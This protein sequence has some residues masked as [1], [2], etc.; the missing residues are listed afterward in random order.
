MTIQ[1]IC[2]RVFGM[3]VA[4]CVALS[5]HAA[6]AKPDWARLTEKEIVTDR[7]I[8]VYRDEAVTGRGQKIG[9]TRKW[10]ATAS[11]RAVEPLHRQLGARVKGRFKII[12]AEVI[13]LPEGAD[14]AAVVAAYEAN[15]SV[16][17]VYP[18]YRYQASAHTPNDA[19]WE[20]LWG[21]RRIRADQAW[22]FFPVTNV[23]PVVVA[24]IDS[25]V[26]MN[27]PDLQGM[28]WTNPGEIPGNG[29]DDDGNGYIDDV[30]GW[31]FTTMSLQTPAGDND[32]SD[33]NG[34][35]TH[36]AG[37]IAAT[38]DNGIGVAGVCPAVRILPVRGLNAEG[39][40]STE[41]LGQ[42]IE[43]VA[44]LGTLYPEVK[45]SNNSWGSFGHDMFIMM[46]IE[47]TRMA[48]QLFVAAA[49]NESVNIDFYDSQPGGLPN[50]NIVCVASINESNRLS[51]FSN[52]G[53]ENVDIAA[54][55]GTTAA[56]ATSGRQIM[57][58][59]FN[60]TGSDGEYNG[61]SG[62]SMASPHV[63][64][65]AAYLWAI[66][67]NLTYQQVAA[68]L[69]TGAAV[70][71][72]LAGRVAGAR[73]LDLM[74]AIESLYFKPF[75]K[76]R[77]Y[78]FPPDFPI[79]DGGIATSELTSNWDDDCTVDISFD[80]VPGPWLTLVDGPAA[81]AAGETAPLV[82]A[83]D[84]DAPD[85]PTV[86]GTYT[87]SV[88][89]TFTPAVGL[90]VTITRFII[91]RLS[92]TYFLQSAPH[93]WVPLSTGAVQVSA[94]QLS[95]GVL[96]LPSD[97][98][99]TYYNIVYSNLYV[100]PNGA[101]LFEPPFAPLAGTGTA[102]PEA[103]AGVAGL[104]PN[105]TATSLSGGSVWYQTNVTIDARQSVVVTWTNVAHSAN[106]A[107]RF[108]YQVVL[109]DTGADECSEI[110]YQYRRVGQ[111]DLI[112]G[113][114]KK[115]TV[116]LQSDG[117]FLAAHYT[118]NGFWQWAPG[119]EYD[120]CPGWVDGIPMEL[121]DAQT[122]RWTWAAREHETVVPTAV[123][124]P[125]VVLSDEIRY[126]I[127][128]SEIIFDLNADDLSLVTTVP[129]LAVG[130]LS[131]G[132][133]RFIV[134]IANAVGEY[135]SVA[136]RVRE[137]A[138][139]DLEQNWNA[140][141]FVSPIRAIPFRTPHMNDDFE[142]GP[143][144]W[145][146]SAFG[147]TTDFT[148]GGWEFGTPY[149]AVPL[150]PAAAASGTNCWGTFLGGP[151]WVSTNGWNNG[152]YPGG[153]AFAMKAQLDSPN[154][155]VGTLPTVTFRAF[156]RLSGAT[157]T[158]IA[159]P[160]SAGVPVVLGT[161][162]G[163]SWGQW[164]AF[165]YRLPAALYDKEVRIRF[166]VE[167]GYG[168]TDVGL[169]ID[170]VELYSVA[171]PGVYF[172]KVLPE[173]LAAPVALTSGAVVA[174]NTYTARVQDVEGVFASPVAGV[175]VAVGLRVAFDPMEVGGTATSSVPISATP[176][177]Y[178]S[179]RV[180]IQG[181]ASV[182][183]VADR[184]SFPILQLAGALEA[185]PKHLIAKT[186]AAGVRD[187]LNRPL[188]GNGGDASASYQILWVG[189]NGVIDPPA[190][191]GTPT[192]DDRVLY[193]VGPGSPVEL[194]GSVAVAADV[195]LFSRTF[196]HGLA[197]NALVYARAWDGPTYEQSVAY[198]HSDLK[199]ITAVSGETVDFGSWIVGTP[200]HYNRDLNGDT[201]PDGYSVTH[202]LDPRE[203]PDPAADRLRVLAAS[204]CVKSGFRPIR[205]DLYNGFAYI[206]YI[207]NAGQNGAVEVRN[208][209]LTTLVQTVTNG[210][211][212]AN[213]LLNVTGLAIDR[214]NAKLYV[215]E[216]STE[217]RI[218]RFAIAANGTLAYEAMVQHTKT[219][220]DVAVGA[221]GGVYVTDNST[222]IKRYGALLAGAPASVYPHHAYQ[223][224]RV[225]VFG[226]NLYRSFLDSTY[227]VHQIQR[228]SLPGGSVNATF[229]NTSL[230]PM[231]KTAGYLN[232]PAK[233]A[234][235]VAGRL[236]VADRGN[237]RLQVFNTNGAFLAM[238]PTGEPA[239]SALPG[240]FNQPT[241]LCVTNAPFGDHV[242]YVADEGNERVQRLVV[243]LDVDNDGMDDVWESLHGLDPTDPGDAAL[244]NDGDGLS[245]LGEY[246]LRRDPNDPD[247]DGDGLG[248]SFDLY[249]RP[250]VPLGA[251]P[252]VVT[253]LA[254]VVSADGTTVAITVFYNKSE[255]LNAPVQISL[256]GGAYLSPVAMTADGATATYLYVV[257]PGDAGWVT[258]AVT[259]PFQDPPLYT[260]P[261]A[262]ELTP[263]A[264]VTLTALSAA[265]GLVGAGDVVVITAQF[266]SA[267]SDAAVTI[268]TADG[269]TVVN[270]AA[271]TPSVPIPSVQWFFN[272]AVAPIPTNLWYTVSVSSTALDGGVSPLQTGF[273]V[274]DPVITAFTMPPPAIT[275]TAL[276]GV[277]YR[278]EARNSLT[279]GTW[280]PVLTT[281]LTGSVTATAPLTALPPVQ[282]ESNRFFRVV[283]P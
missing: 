67:P 216:S 249:E 135:G 85:F 231:P 255:P 210:V 217:R 276:T 251:I 130:A 57:S 211:G 18:N 35:G 60:N 49:G 277:V 162:T 28:I 32:P 63:A 179:L 244:D 10:G 158:V 134:D 96:P 274:I 153:E 221:D 184:V 192:G 263:T 201:I 81:L 141:A 194:F 208:A 204:S 66:N 215:T 202:G 75:D 271:M 237:D 124:I 103:S 205:V 258:V 183:G 257:Q 92:K 220:Q 34:H 230:V 46:M 190:T 101:I 283:A 206:L 108:E 247:S 90:P 38:M 62:T 213:P 233:V 269:Q 8:V 51:N 248:D 227:Q 54:P 196:A 176:A 120:P 94:S 70:N 267:V 207:S 252:A 106:S 107:T 24:V 89:V 149:P 187:W 146:A 14:L 88:I 163:S 47:Q 93:D 154:F 29:I 150:G 168:A 156:W 133:E 37:T 240:R 114:A 169:Y 7:V 245:N 170:D 132:G 261:D 69:Y 278:V 22:Q 159:V 142:R 144:L 138:V 166:L 167:S 136:L 282:A 157:A 19:L 129:G 113:M 39:S 41:G 238:T 121:A 27:H 59:W 72:H 214:A 128:F 73:Q 275:W 256:S 145:K 31:D 253:N 13:Q 17:A 181:N 48:G 44:V 143:G 188:R 254:A 95:G 98:L 151:G 36:V 264:A 152:W 77:F 65:A 109:F 119:M 224:S 25:G 78:G 126:E 225:T 42:A 125:L 280:G 21:M 43:Y 102:L 79:S 279:S 173:P 239:P 127:R 180:P 55:G 140:E 33:E 212:A 185:T 52:Y 58:T 6:G 20:Q 100:R 229:G 68:A 281:N 175:S 91:F 228:L 9:L 118:V 161:I 61:I 232:M 272:H 84:P 259:G 2:Y 219:P 195:G 235:G 197:S 104:F 139:F 117:S 16:K 174:Y 137:A 165:R 148:D 268:E 189:P 116:G 50:D 234:Q 260:V 250:A 110:W 82:V 23:A 191:N 147:G 265:P 80:G 266:D 273:A 270:A 236:Y 86:P 97:F 246:R 203:M 171:D 87:N 56:A 218:Y 53:I 178:A 5:A 200:I 186:G 4:V 111:S 193:S 99:F 241:G 12:P 122:L 71:P 64:G 155:H 209:A 115:A 182:R 262:F 164:R 1:G 15:P 223:I 3:G 40:G 242:L 30:N 76:I 199:A 112:N 243:I 226:N 222:A 172:L 26:R 177:S 131:G 45:L 160:A 74:G 123:I 11:P 105:W 198:G 83:I